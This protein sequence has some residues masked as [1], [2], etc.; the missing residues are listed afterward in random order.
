[1]LFFMLLFLEY[2]RLTLEVY[3]VDSGCLRGYLPKTSKF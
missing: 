2:Q 1:M 3:Q